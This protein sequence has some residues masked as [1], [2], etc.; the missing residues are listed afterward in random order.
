MNDFNVNL[1]IEGEHIDFLI[2]SGS[3][4][5][6]IN[7]KTFSS[8]NKIKPLKVRKTD[9]TVLTHGQKS[10]TLQIKVVVTLP[11]NHAG[12]AYLFDFYIV[13]TDNKNLL[14]GTT[15]VMLS[16]LYLPIN[17]IDTDKQHGN[18]VEHSKISNIP[19][20]LKPLIAQYSDTIFSGNIGKIK[21]VTVKLHIDPNVPP[22]TQREH[23][24]PSL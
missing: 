20:R 23:L 13:D 4:L 1:D 6:I 24:F 10:P 17:T 16:L 8:L 9:T 18:E 7:L 22:M 3:A 14:S 21:G 5:N 19:D 12:T 2:D 11:V 15:A